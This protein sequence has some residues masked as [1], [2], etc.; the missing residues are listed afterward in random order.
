[1]RTSVSSYSWTSFG[2]NE[3][4]LEN[5]EIYARQIK[6]IL[7]FLIE[8]GR[9]GIVSPEDFKTTDLNNALF[10]SL[11]PLEIANYIT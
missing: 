8:H 7:Q 5:V 11:N 2:S 6:P 1:M 9:E 4:R 10:G 3:D